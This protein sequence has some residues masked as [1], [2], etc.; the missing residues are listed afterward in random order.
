MTV[1]RRP[2]ACPSLFITSLGNNGS[3]YRALRLLVKVVMKGGGAEVLLT[4]TVTRYMCVLQYS[5]CDICHYNP[6][7][8]SHNTPPHPFLEEEY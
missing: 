6:P 8:P 1:V 4:N 5:G 2:A 7:K 3:V